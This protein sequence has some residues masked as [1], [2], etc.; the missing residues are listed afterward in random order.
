MIT[1]SLFI[2]VD[3]FSDKWTRIDKDLYSLA[4]N[5]ATPNLV[6]AILRPRQTGNK[7][8]TESPVTRLTGNLI[9][10]AEQVETNFNQCIKK[11]LIDYPTCTGDIVFDPASYKKWGAAFTCQMKCT[12]GNCLYTSESLDFYEKV[13][14]EDTTCDDGAARGRTAAKINVQIQVA[15]SK[16]PIGNTALRQLF[17]A[18]DID[19]PCVSSMQR[20]SNRI[21]DAMVGFNRSQLDTNRKIIKQ[22]V[23]MRNWN[24]NDPHG[25]NVDIVALSDTCYNN[26]IKGRS[27]Y[28][29]GTQAW[30]PLICGEPGL[31]MPVAFNTRSKLCSCVEGHHGA[32]CQRNYPVERPMGNVEFEFGKMMGEDMTTSDT[33]LLVRELVTDGD[34]HTLKG[35]L[36]AMTTNGK[37]TTKG[38]CT[39][40]LTKTIGRNIS[41]A[42]LSDMGLGGTTILIRN[43]NKRMV[44]S[45]IEKR[46][47]WEFRKAHAKCRGDIDRL[48]KMCANIQR[49]IIA[50]VTG[51]TDICRRLSLVC[52]AHRKKENPKVITNQEKHAENTSLGLQ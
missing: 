37:T 5:P 25:E 3:V 14:K 30:C 21:G 46:C 16:L 9:V 7:S 26:P 35:M 44:A 43:Q 34:S 36:P 15:L 48:K 20:S 8:K 17:V 41:R 22:C 31:E 42:N 32:D 19:A 28:Q 24:T 47:S 50:C 52:A 27:F 1:N 33:R 10:R 4:L 23:K 2:C 49:G 18:C 39:R 51:E 6:P 11:H 13:R 38:D 29:P 40:H 45:F 12:A